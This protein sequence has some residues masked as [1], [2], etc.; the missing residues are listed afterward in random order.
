[1]S[2]KLNQC[3]EN[4]KGEYVQ[5]SFSIFVPDMDVLSFAEHLRNSIPELEET[6]FL[7]TQT[8]GIAL[9]HPDG[10]VLIVV[11]RSNAT[12]FEGDTNNPLKMT[13]YAGPNLLRKLRQEIK[14]TYEDNKQL[15][16][17]W[18]YDQNK[19]ATF[20]TLTLKRGLPIYPE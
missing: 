11:Y 16:V 18:W 12:L 20:M 13:I 17:K 19:A 4:L 9:I 14:E 8:D 15:T 10:L 7:P 2:V 6:S 5:D 1:M 3:L